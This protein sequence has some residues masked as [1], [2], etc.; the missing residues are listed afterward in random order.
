MDSVEDHT[1]IRVGPGI[2]NR[3]HRGYQ[4]PE[5]GKCM[6]TCRRTQRPPR[7]SLAPDPFW[8]IF[9]TCLTAVVRF[10]RARKIAR[11]GERSYGNPDIPSRRYERRKTLVRG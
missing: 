5:V 3:K 2:D 4:Q 1:P 9:L 10:V 11:R 6:N 7:E 8:P